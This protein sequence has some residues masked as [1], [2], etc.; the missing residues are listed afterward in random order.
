[1]NTAT[2]RRSKIGDKCPGCGAA[3]SALNAGGYRK[4]CLDCVNSMPPLPSA[5]GGYQIRG[6]R[7]NFQWH[8]VSR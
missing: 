5:P 4:F 2:H 3:L 6:K 8:R 1:M 7:G